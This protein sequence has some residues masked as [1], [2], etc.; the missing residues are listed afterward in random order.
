MEPVYMMLGHAAGAAAHL[1]LAEKTSVQQVDV[2]KLRDLLRQEKAIVDAG[3]QPPVSI[4][5]TPVHPQPGERVTFTLKT[6][7]LKQP[8]KHVWWD[9]AGNGVVAAQGNRAEHTF[10]LDKVYPVSLLVE[11]SA[12]LRRI[13]R[14]ELPVGLATE[15]DVTMDEFDADLFGR[16]DGAYPEI[17]LASGVRV[18]DVFYGP[19]V[20][21]DSVRNGKK[22]A[23]RARFQPTIPRT[24][25]Y[26]V[27]LGFRA[28]RK[29][30]TNVPITI[31]HAGGSAKQK[32]DQR[33]EATPFPF[34]SLGEFKFRAGD[35][36]FVELTNH[37]TDGRVAI[38]AVRWIWL[39]E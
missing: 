27:C 29:Q 17:V 1:A 37:E 26:E 13:V 5:W 23:A 21:F 12:G 6:G 10:E 32:V 8:L 35:S 28:V 15:H 19:G 20:N 33:K 34:V 18:P 30:A 31:R 25:R 22:V 14:A 39:G 38:D 9:F 3:Y 4:A 7:E 16:W 36:G 11:D 2:A 24:G